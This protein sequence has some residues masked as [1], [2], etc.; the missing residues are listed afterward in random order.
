MPCLCQVTRLILCRIYVFAPRSQ[1][2]VS[3]QLAPASRL[4][5][6]PEASDVADMPK[7]LRPC[8]ALRLCTCQALIFQQMEPKRAPIKKSASLW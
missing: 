5:T 1:H 3:G 7:V 2:D 8:K 4:C 6:A